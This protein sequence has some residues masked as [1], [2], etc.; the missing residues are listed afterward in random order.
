MAAPLD[1]LA[2]LAVLDSHGVEFVMV[3]GMAAV[4]HGSPTTTNDIDIVADPD[5][6]NLVRLADALEEL[7]ARIRSPADPGGVAFSPHPDLLAGVSVLT[8]HTRFGDLD[9]VMTPAGLEGYG[10]IRRRAETYQV[11]G[12]TVTVANLEDIIRSKRAAGRP[13]DR[14]MLPILEALAEE[15]RRASDT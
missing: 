7:E 9:L 11:D 6:A 14:A 13:R 3:G 15:R 12:M 5:R 1:P 4:L 8:M 10:E 2:L